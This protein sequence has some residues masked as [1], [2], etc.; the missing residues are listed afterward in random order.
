MSASAG[1]S[2]R[3]IPNVIARRSAAK[4]P[5]SSPRRTAKC[6]P[7]RTAASTDSPS[8][9]RGGGWRRMSATA[10]TIAAKVATSSAYAQP[11]PATAITMPPSAGP[12]TMVS[13]AR[14]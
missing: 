5:M 9:R 11:I 2:A 6:R 13:W 3:G 4:L 10:P 8:V 1:K 14:P 7:A 12:I